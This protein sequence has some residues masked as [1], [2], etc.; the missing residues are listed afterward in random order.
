MTRRASNTNCYELSL[1]SLVD[2]FMNVLGILMLTA[3][4]IAIT[5]PA[6]KPE[7]EQR[8]TST[9]TS[10]D[11]EEP[12]VVYLAEERTVATQPYYLLLQSDGARPI[13]P[14]N[15]SA[16]YPY[17]NIVRTSDEDRLSPL[18]GKVLSLAQY[19]Q[20]VSSI[21]PQERHVVF[22]VKPQGAALYR[23]LREIT[24]E[25]GVQSGWTT[26]ELNEIGLTSS[27]GTSI[28]RVQ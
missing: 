21:S 10:K 9:Q 19:K 16:S 11:D 13:D 28:D 18:A 23:Q 6:H 14:A 24:S 27:G 25:A 3:I 1:D 26:W 12:A 22:L 4:S 20:I 15:I 8:K 5:V 7:S 17:F 2:V